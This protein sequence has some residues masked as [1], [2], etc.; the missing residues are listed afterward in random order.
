M[1]QIDLNPD[2]GDTLM[3]LYSPQPGLLTRNRTPASNET[4]ARIDLVAGTVYAPDW[5]SIPTLTAHWIC[6][7]VKQGAKKMKR[8]GIL[9]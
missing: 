3:H 2:T 8:I 5:Y 4:G 6:A 7:G 9:Q 1:K